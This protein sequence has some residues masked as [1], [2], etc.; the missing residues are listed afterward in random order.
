[1]PYTE[2]KAPPHDADMEKAVVSS[3][4]FFPDAIP[5]IWNILQPEDFYRPDYGAV[6]RTILG[7]KTG[8][9]VI[10]L[11]TLKAELEA[12]NLFERVGGGEFLKDIAGNI[13]PD[14]NALHYAREIKRLSESRQIHKAAYE[15]AAKPDPS[16]S[17]LEKA[18]E[19]ARANAYVKSYAEKSAKSIDEY[20]ERLR[21]KEPR[22]KTGFSKLDRFTGG[23]L[24]IPS[25]ATVGAYA[26]AETDFELPGVY[27]RG[28]VQRRFAGMGL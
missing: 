19:Q 24:I 25:V 28:R 20:R 15:I 11:I 27:K 22:I 26:A 4:V 23:G 10:D 17:D 7:M 18:L 13:C 2:T 5:V 14:V 21:V 9:R 6:Y 8:G 16:V 1:M 3:M 12:G